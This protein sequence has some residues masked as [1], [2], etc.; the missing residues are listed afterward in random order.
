MAS[1]K[2][3]QDRGCPA[4]LEGAVLWRLGPEL[5][6]CK[7]K[8]SEYMTKEKRRQVSGILLEWADELQ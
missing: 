1:T 5:I 8:N 2:V 6:Q 3:F 4:G 7:L